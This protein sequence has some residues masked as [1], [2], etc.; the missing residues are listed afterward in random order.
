MVST[1]L[2][3]TLVLLLY[4]LSYFSVWNW[5]HFCIRR[6]SQSKLFT[7]K[8]QCQQ[9]LTHYLKI[10][11]HPLCLWRK[12]LNLLSTTL[13][14]EVFQYIHLWFDTSFLQFYFWRFNRTLHLCWVRTRYRTTS[15]IHILSVSTRF[16]LSSS[17]KTLI[18]VDVMF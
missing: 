2:D 16:L 12:Y 17:R 18:P 10:F 8:C 1:R 4:L 14:L 6:A 13:G 7:V 3:K 5:Y 11:P 15:S 9:S